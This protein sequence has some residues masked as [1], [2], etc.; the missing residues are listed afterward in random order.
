MQILRW[1]RSFEVVLDAFA[2]ASA[3]DLGMGGMGEPWVVEC[4]QVRARGLF[5][6]VMW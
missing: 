1:N 6:G 5:S 4:R 3:K 2:D